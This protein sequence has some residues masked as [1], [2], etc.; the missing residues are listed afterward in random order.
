MI[1]SFVA[2]PSLSESP[3]LV[4]RLPFRVLVRMLLA[5]SPLPAQPLLA[6][7]R[8]P[9]QH[10]GIITGMVFDA[11]TEQPLAEVI[12]RVVGQDVTTQSDD[13][14]RFTLDNVRPG[15]VQLEARRLG[16]APLL[17]G[18]VAVSAGKPVVV[19]LAMRRLQV[20]LQTI[21]VRPSPFP[22][23]P[24][25][26][27]P[28]SSTTLS[29]EELRRT[30]GAS[31][32]VLQA[33]SIAPGVATTTAGRNDLF[34]RGGAAYENLFVVDN[35][36]VPNINHFGTQGN[37][38]G[39]LSLIN[40]R[41]VDRA[42]LS[43]GGFGVRYGDRLS[44]S[45]VLT[46][47]EGTRERW[48][49]ELNVAATQYGAI[50]EGPIGPDASILFNVRRSY[51][52]LLFR[53][54]GQSFIPSYTD[55]V[56]KASWHPDRRN[57]LSFLVVGAVDNV[58]FSNDDADQRVDNSRIL[59]PS[60]DQYFAGFT[61]KRL[62]ASGVLT[63]TLGRTWTR[64][65]TAQ[66]DSL[67]PPTP[68]F[69]AN[70]TEREHSL[71]SDLT[72]QPWPGLEVEAGHIIKLASTLR[73]DVTI[74][75]FLRRDAAGQPRPLRVDTAFSAL[76]NATYAQASWQAMPALRLTA[77]VR[78]D[79]YGFLDRAFAVSPRV[80]ATLSAGEQ[81]SIT[82]AAGRYHQPPPFIWLV[83]DPQ[84]RRTLAPLRADQVVVGVQRLLGREWR[85]Q[86]EGFAK[87]YDRYAARAF[88]PNAVLQPSGFEDA[89]TDIPFGLEPLSSRGSGRVW[90]AEA[91]LQKALGEVPVYGVASVSYNR[92]RFRGLDGRQTRGAFDTPL[93]ANV[94]AGWRPS[95]RWEFSG[96][97]RTASGLPVT[98]FVEEGANAGSLDFTRYN[99]QRLPRF[100]S[101]DA[102]VDRRWRVGRT[103]LVTFLDIQNVNGRAN[104]SAL[105]WDV[106]AQRVERSEG[107]RVLPSIGVNWEF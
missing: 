17:R 45:T 81:T 83:G 67:S 49:G 89:F 98:P 9:A 24:S 16:Y 104:V 38:G 54:L 76:R 1:L 78:G 63:T 53:A 50:L 71:R 33:L 58:A 48:S 29:S 30:P 99:T 23:Q 97:M 32:D 47:R 61:W 34:V 60:Q 86:V 39:P 7:P 22:A 40:I 94:V 28:V 3:A 2:A 102:R 82:V 66:F 18:D 44:S 12:V 8:A 107:L 10:P 11:V 55:A 88:R 101:V 5:A 100:F 14:G 57:A 64:Y 96:R 72:W 80:S 21:T 27:T 65:A 59:A 105:R 84:N 25:P 85:W 95:A 31:E 13:A 70:T 56:V 91:Q 15:I 41:F 69:E 6:Q 4:R 74:P 26:T 36:E 37:T 42:T 43:A 92:T 106:R 73:Y 19:S 51:L 93:V 20:Q 87:R 62:F 35:V 68:I 75:G 103:Q 79:H 52:D 46:L 77:G 90:G